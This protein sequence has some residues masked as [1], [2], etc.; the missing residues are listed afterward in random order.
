MLP[1]CGGLITVLRPVREII[2]AVAHHAVDQNQRNR[3]RNHA[4]RN[5]VEVPRGLGL[6]RRRNGAEI[7]EIAHAKSTGRRRISASFLLGH[8]V[9]ARET[10]EKP[11][12]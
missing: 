7:K 4:R 1:E 8:D 9:I 10:Q 2:P 5:G 6:G 3:P 11:E 12:S